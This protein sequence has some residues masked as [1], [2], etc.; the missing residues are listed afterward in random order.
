MLRSVLTFCSIM[1][2]GWFGYWFWGANANKTAVEDFLASQE[3]W[4]IT[5][6]QS[7]QRGFP[8]RY[9]V[10]LDDLRLVSHDGAYSVLLSKLQIMRLSYRSSHWII[11]FPQEF[12]LTGP[13]G[14]TQINATRLLGSAVLTPTGTRIALE[15][16]DL[17]IVSDEIF[18][19]PHAVV[20]AVIAEQTATLGMW[21]QNEAG[22]ELRTRQSVSLGLDLPRL[23]FDLGFPVVAEIYSSDGAP[24]MQGELTGLGL[25]LQ[26]QF[27]GKTTCEQTTEIWAIC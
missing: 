8:N 10:T 21:I 16:D 9:D 15:A 13:K 5:Y 2:I 22:Q 25:P 3:N 11:G 6:S 14:K 26:I 18:A 19:T 20:S 17:R 24:Q 12:T 23:P 1:A 7:T 27:S 4:A